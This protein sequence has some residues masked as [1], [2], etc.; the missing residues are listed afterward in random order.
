MKDED[1]GLM[2]DGCPDA[3]TLAAY[4]DGTLAH[5]AR[6]RV[7]AHAADCGDCRSIIAETIRFQDNDAPASDVPLQFPRWTRPRRLLAGLGALAAAA[8]LVLAVRA[9]KETPAGNADPRPALA[10]LVAAVGETRPFE[11]RLTGGFRYGPLQ[12]VMRSGNGAAPSATPAVRI[13]A[14][15][16]DQQRLE[17]PSPEATAA[18]ASAELVVGRV[19]SA[20]A[21]LEDVTRQRPQSAPAWSDLAAAYLVAAARDGDRAAAA[22]ALGAAD[23]ARSLDAQQPEALFNRALALE[24]LGR[25]DEARAAW[26]DLGS[27]P[28]GDGWADEARRRAAL[29]ERP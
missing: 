16:L 11:A 26:V 2:D 22:R 23:R 29:L 1:R 6:G 28:G 14:A 25:A 10:E 12:P 15:R 19:S 18:F 13:A 20:V 27:R 8:A 5:G 3:E 7:E 4:L 17:R 9:T 24:A 21:L